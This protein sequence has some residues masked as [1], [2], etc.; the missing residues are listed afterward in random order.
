MQ[1][2]PFS[3]NDFEAYLRPI[4]VAFIMPHNLPFRFIL[5]EVI[6][7]TSSHW[8]GANQFFFP[9]FDNQ[10]NH[11]DF[12]KWLRLLKKFDPDKIVS[13]AQFPPAL[14]D[15][16]R[17]FTL[18]KSDWFQ[19]NGQTVGSPHMIHRNFDGMKIEDLIN[20]SMQPVTFDEFQLTGSIDH[21][22]W[23]FSEFG[24]LGRHLGSCVGPKIAVQAQQVTV[25]QIEQDARDIAYHR[26]NGNFAT[27]PLSLSM[28]F[29]G[30]GLVNGIEV[31]Y[32]FPYI[33]VVGDTAAD[34]A[35]YTSLKLMYDGVFWIKPSLLTI[36]NGANAPGEFNMLLH[37]IL[38]DRNRQDDALIVSATLSVTQ[39][40]VIVNDVL[41]WIDQMY[42]S[43]GNPQFR[44][45]DDFEHAVGNWREWMEIN[46]SVESSMIFEDNKSIQRVPIVTPKHFKPTPAQARY[47]SVLYSDSY[48]F[49]SHPMADSQTVIW[50]NPRAVIKD[51]VR[52]SH[53]GGITFNSV[54]HLTFSSQDLDSVQHGPKLKKPTVFD[55]FTSILSKLNLRPQRT[56]K[57][58]NVS[59]V[60][61]L[62]NGSTSVFSD[63]FFR[64]DTQRI[65]EF[66]RLDKKTRLQKRQSLG[67]LSGA[68]LELGQ[69]FY[70]SYPLATAFNPSLT[71]FT[72][73]KL[74]LWIEQ[75]ILLRGE[76]L[77]CQ[78][79]GWADFYA[80]EDYSRLFACK[81]C[82]AE[83][84]RNINTM[85]NIEPRFLYGLNPLVYGLFDNTSEL[86][87]LGI[88][89]LK[90][91]SKWYLEAEMS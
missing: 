32:F 38:D 82:A 27:S 8:G 79:C 53:H 51:D 67:V 68:G 84:K 76:R 54:K 69:K 77:V 41:N 12:E 26:F 37:H 9:I 15:I 48:N 30:G 2:P 42:N 85:G 7:W 10:E 34:W 57:T 60:L 5:D 49:L 40:D 14:L 90:K 52:R 46:N 45:V 63:D 35:L 80:E 73:E 65:F 89:S 13:I 21:D 24:R 59:S 91:L 11:P 81:R 31:D 74:N 28:K 47:M 16:I 43:L 50:K 58:L 1:K 3:S 23:F 56:I 4:R 44:S 70:F 29:L 22:I 75:G 55:D 25:Q 20:S 87:I 64:N 61:D 6:P 17:N 83:W 33:I 39:L 66:F 19:F 86:T 88:D 72:D 36:N 18:S 71:T 78:R 62:W